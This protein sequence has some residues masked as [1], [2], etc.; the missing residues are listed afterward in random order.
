MSAVEPRTNFDSLQAGM[1]CLGNVIYCVQAYK[2]GAG[3]YR[4]HNFG[5]VVMKHRTD[6][7]FIPIL[8]ELETTNLIVGEVNYLS[9]GSLFHIISESDEVLRTNDERQDFNHGIIEVESVCSQFIQGCLNRYQTGSIIKSPQEAAMVID[10][11]S[12]CSQT[13]KSLSYVYFEAVCLA[14]MLNST[15]ATTQKLKSAGELNNEIYIDLV[16][17]L[18]LAFHNDEFASY[19]F[20]P[21]TKELAEVIAS[22]IE[23]EKLSLD[24]G[25]MQIAVA[26]NILFY[27]GNCLNTK[28]AIRGN[29]FFDYCSEPIRG[30]ILRTRLD[31]SVAFVLTKYFEEMKFDIVINSAIEKGEIGITTCI[32]D[33]LVRV[34][35][36]AYDSQIKH[37]NEMHVIAPKLIPIRW[38][39]DAAERVQIQ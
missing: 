31:E 16:H 3:T 34:V 36:G 30:T 26:N 37:V 32:S 24:M 20:H 13:F 18:K 8:F 28:E 5:S 4:I 12:E 23:Q 35:R 10:N 29:I 25:A 27:I 6:K 22:M 33:R 7:T 9:M 11:I 19:S 14:L 17:N 38:H 15:D 39:N 2:E 21:T 1:G